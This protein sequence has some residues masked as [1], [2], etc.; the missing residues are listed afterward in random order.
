MWSLKSS[1]KPA[2]KVIRSM[3]PDHLIVNKKAMEME[4][5]E[6]LV[7]KFAQRLKTDRE[8]EDQVLDFL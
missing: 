8:K 7:T 2:S 3:T 4:I 6:T 1:F 5:Y